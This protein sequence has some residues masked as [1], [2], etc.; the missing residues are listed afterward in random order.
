VVTVADSLPSGLA[1]DPPGEPLRFSFDAPNGHDA[2]WYGPGVVP[3]DPG[4]V[5]TQDGEVLAFSV[6]RPERIPADADPSGYG[7]FDSGGPPRVT[8]VTCAGEWSAA[9]R[10]CLERLAVTAVPRPR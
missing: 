7:L 9:Q 2:G 5:T 1:H 3:G 10:R 8:L 6:V 4:D